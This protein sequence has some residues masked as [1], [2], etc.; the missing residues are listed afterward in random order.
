MDK[1]KA[2]RDAHTRRS[3]RPVAENDHHA[4]ISSNMQGCLN[5]LLVSIILVDSLK[6]W[7]A[8]SVL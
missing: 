6:C 5:E 7:D 3:A 8:C 1:P 4:K 2:L